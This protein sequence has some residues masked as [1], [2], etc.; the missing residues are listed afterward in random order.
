MQPSPSLSVLALLAALTCILTTAASLPAQAGAGDAGTFRITVDGREVGTDT[1]TI[2]RSGAGTNAVTTATGRVRL[3][4]IGRA[5][6]LVPD[7]QVAGFQN[8]LVRYSLRPGPE[9]RGSR[10][11]GSVSGGVFTAELAT[12]TGEAMRQFLVADQ[13]VL[14]DDWVAHHHH[15]LTQRPREGEVA[16]VIPSRDRQVTGVLTNEGEQVIEVGG[17][18]VSATRLALQLDEEVGGARQIWTDQLNRVLRVD[19]PTLG[20]SAVR[21]RVPR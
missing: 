16:V 6:D 4:L 14:L 17:R 10:V 20:Y 8:S 13:A 3:Q 1:F 7:L 21:T 18:A 19:I 9:G 15:F 11:T 12:P 2:R 5:V